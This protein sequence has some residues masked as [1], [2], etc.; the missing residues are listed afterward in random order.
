MILYM[1]KQTVDRYKLKMP[2]EMN[3]PMDKLAQAVIAQE[4]G[5]KVCEWGGKLFYFDHRKCIQLVNFASKLTLFLFDIKMKDIPDLGD[6][7][8][9]YIFGL[10]SEDEEMLDALKHMFKVHPMMCFARL[11]DKSAISTLNTT[12]VGFAEDGYRFYDFISDGILRTR[13]INYRVNFEW[14]FTMKIDGKTEYIH[15]G[16]RFREIVI[17]KYGAK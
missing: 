12:Q 5:D 7:V 2:E 17:D 11:K 3:A 9:E 16:E 14:L 4:C 6:Y 8:V 10:Y 1:T 15:A 13:E